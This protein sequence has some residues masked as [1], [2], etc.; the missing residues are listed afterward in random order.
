MERM[1]LIYNKMSL[2]RK[3]KYTLSH[4]HL[5]RGFFICLRFKLYAIIEVEN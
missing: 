4:V 5:L 3:P 2:G 1:E